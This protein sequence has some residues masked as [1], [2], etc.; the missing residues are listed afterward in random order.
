MNLFCET[1]RLYM[2]HRIAKPI[3]VDKATGFILEADALEIEAGALAQLR[4]VLMKKPKASDVQFVLSR[5]DNLISTQT[6]T[7]DGRLV[8]LAYPKF[9][10]IVLGF[11][12]P[13]LRVVAV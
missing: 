4:T 12:N 10:E 2:L 11:N 1:V 3:R 13:A 8:P 7:G 9:I 6:L 5:T